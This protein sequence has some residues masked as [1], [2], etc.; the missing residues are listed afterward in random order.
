MEYNWWPH[1]ERLLIIFSVVGVGVVLYIY[2]MMSDKSLDLR[3]ISREDFRRIEAKLDTVLSIAA[4]NAT[5]KRPLAPKSKH[6][7][8]KP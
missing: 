8:D 5:E 6:I 2:H 4:Y 3:F 1:I 7:L